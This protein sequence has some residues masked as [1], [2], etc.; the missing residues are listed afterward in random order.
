MFSLVRVLYLAATSF[1]LTMV[2]PADSF[3]FCVNELAIHPNVPKLRH[4]NGTNDIVDIPVPVTST[5]SSPE[6][7]QSA[8]NGAFGSSTVAYAV[9]VGSLGFAIAGLF[10]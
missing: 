6:A 3:K 4:S 9:V 2:F 1:Q 10:I 8:R 7:T 5:S